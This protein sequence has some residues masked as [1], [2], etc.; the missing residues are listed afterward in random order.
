MIRAATPSDLW[1]LRR[2]PRSWVLLFNEAM[3]AFP[4]RASLYLLRSIFEG[5]GAHGATYI[6][7][8][9]RSQAVVQLRGRNGRPE[10]DIVFLAI[11]GA[12]R[13][14]TPTDYDVWHRL[15]E[16]ACICAGNYRIQ[17]IF[18]PLSQRH[19]D[20]RELFRQLGFQAYAR[21]AVLRL[22]GPD[23]NQGT[24]LA[25]MRTQ[26]R[27]SV[28][29]IHKLY[30]STTPRSVQ[31][32]EALNAR[33]WSLPMSQ[34]WARPTRRSWVLGSDDE[35]V[36]W[37]NLTS[38]PGGHAFRLLLHPDNRALAPDILRFGLGQ[39]ADALPV[40]LLLREYQSELLAPL[41]ELGFQG[42]GE[43]TLLV[44]NMTASVRRP[45][46][47]PAIEQGLEPNI[48]IPSISRSQGGNDDLW[49][50]NAK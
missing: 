14:G 22:E 26:S 7:R 28:W 23:M 6:Y 9:G 25:P 29:A 21:Q 15:L 20:L 39:V 47:L 13:Q 49:L 44:K 50:N 8:D 31:Q 19:D 24:S 18:A 37:L 42:L 16:H 27:H 48:P 10:Q 4:H 11:H 43:Q 45:V 12:P 41:E 35:L 30:G 36:A 38:G 34:R 40:Y 33:D 17:R 2:K 46:L 3:L 5:P 1:R 32:A